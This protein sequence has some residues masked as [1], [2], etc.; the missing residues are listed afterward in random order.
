MG[1][2]R[3]FGGGSGHVV[4]RG[5]GTWTLEVVDNGG[6]SDGQTVITF[7]QVI[8]LD[9]HFTSRIPVEE[10]LSTKWTYETLE[11][12]LEA[13]EEEEDAS[14]VWNVGPERPLTLAPL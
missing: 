10:E 13:E 7:S 4:R 3:W 9:R 11:M 2:R 14:R 6:P 1:V 5:E 12:M 8:H